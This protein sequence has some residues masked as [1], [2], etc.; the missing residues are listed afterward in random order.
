MPDSRKVHHVE[1]FPETA[2][3]AGIGRA[4]PRTSATAQVLKYLI[5]SA[6][7]LAIGLF[8][9]FLP[10]LTSLTDATKSAAGN[11]SKTVVPVTVERAE[12]KS[13]PTEIQNIGN[14]E[15][16]SVVNVMAQVGGQLTHVYFKQGQYIK[17]G[18]LLFQIDPR[19][20]KAALAQALGNVAKDKAQVHAAE[21]SLAKDQATERQVRANMNK[22]VTQMKYAEVEKD[23]Y[24]HL[25]DQGAVSHEQ[26][27][28]M[29]TNH[30]SMLSTVKSD[31]AVIENAQAMMNSDRAAI[32]TAK[33]T[34]AADEAAADNARI[35]LGFTE[36]RS[37]VD[38]RTG[39]L[40]VYEGNVVVANSNTPLVVIYQID[41]IYVTF[42]LP[43]KDLSEIK[44]SN[45]VA[46]LKVQAL[47][48]GVKQD[49]A[50]GAVSFMDNT[51]D[52]A[53]GAIRLRATFAN[54]NRALWPGQYVDVIVTLPSEGEMIVVPTRAIQTGQQEQLVFVVGNSQTVT[55]RSVE[56]KRT[57]GEYS[58]ITK[59]IHPG[60]V[61]VTD[62][63]LQLTPGARVQIKTEG[64]AEQNKLP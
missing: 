56:V 59:G 17:K 2:S 24:A 4:N 38:G 8:V 11:H 5:V 44:H 36:I 10:K 12:T 54:S 18:D 35:N 20:Y 13:L 31:W 19:P 50:N 3:R 14:V 30:E 15:A 62:G 16:F 33:G 7:V 55:V 57:Y 63:Q 25:V 64:K 28:Q 48:E 52:K 42:S 32:E 53:T 22:D 23:R 51:V 34:L 61:V 60:D 43:E 26:A 29:K 21:A 47:I 58:V 39:S 1:E 37:P 6:C 46:G 49:A 40:N 45:E 27:D 9:Y 41:P